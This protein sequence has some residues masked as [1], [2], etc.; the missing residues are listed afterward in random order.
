MQQFDHAR[1]GTDGLFLGIDGA[2]NQ[3]ASFSVIEYSPFAGTL[4][5][6][7]P[8]LHLVADGASA[9]QAHMRRDASNTA[10]CA[11]S[12]W[13]GRRKTPRPLADPC[14]S[15]QVSGQAGTYAHQFVRQLIETSSGDA[16]S[17]L[18]AAISWRVDGRV[19]VV[20]DVAVRHLIGVDGLQNDAAD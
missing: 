14:R 10:I 1:M 7:G 19:D 18:T 2:L 6:D 17:E 16:R 20:G 4:H 13:S 12:E 15:P 9:Y 11:R 5:L 3:A 8:I